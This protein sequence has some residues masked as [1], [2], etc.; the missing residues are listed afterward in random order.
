MKTL[1]LPENSSV[2]NSIKLNLLATAS[3]GTWLSRSSS[4]RCRSSMASGRRWSRCPSSPSSLCA[5]A[6]KLFCHLL[7]KNNLW[8]K[9]QILKLSLNNFI[10]QTVGANHIESSLKQ[11]T[12][13]PKKYH[14][15]NL[16]Q[17]EESDSKFSIPFPF[18]R[19]GHTIYML[20]FIFISNPPF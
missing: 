3:T 13:R 20:S 12:R 15:Y 17:V 2:L 9:M 19:L 18:I 16:A 7:Y 1:L 4:S 14:F 5:F 10:Q 6:W 11:R 8:L